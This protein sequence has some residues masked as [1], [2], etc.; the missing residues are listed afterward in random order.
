[1]DVGNRPIIIHV[2][3]GMLEHS[4][5]SLRQIF[6][7]LKFSSFVKLCDHADERIFA[8]ICNHLRHKVVDDLKN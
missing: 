7:H 4:Y 6:H 3:K 1:M 8:V 5:R 2:I